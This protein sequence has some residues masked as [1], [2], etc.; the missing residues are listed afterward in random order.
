MLLTREDGAIVAKRYSVVDGGLIGVAVLCDDGST[1]LFAENAQPT[2]KEYYGIEMPDDAE[3][4]KKKLAVSEATGWKFPQEFPWLETDETGEAVSD[5]ERDERLMIWL[6]SAIVDDY[7]L[8][9]R[10]GER[11]ASQYAPGFALMRALSNGEISRLG[12]RERDLGGPASSVPCVTCDASLEELNQVIA[13][14]DLLFI[15]V[16]DEGSSEM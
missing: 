3:Y 11:T 7:D 14:H 10:W 9:E 15:F 5:A 2:Y 1:E 8:L 6:N 13:R 16:D 4:E 12:M